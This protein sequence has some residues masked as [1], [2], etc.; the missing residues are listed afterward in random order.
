[1]RAYSGGVVQMTIP[2]RGVLRGRVILDTDGLQ[3]SQIMWD[4]ESLPCWTAVRP[5]E[6]PLSPPASCGMA[7]A[8]AAASYVRTPRPPLAPS[9]ARASTPDDISA[10]PPL[11]KASFLVAVQRSPSPSTTYQ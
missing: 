8:P 11:A 10:W 6:P 9:G 5:Q 3:V 1:M 4:D 2:G 7:A